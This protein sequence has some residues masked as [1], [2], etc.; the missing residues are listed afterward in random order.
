[1]QSVP[2]VED[3]NPKKYIIMNKIQN[4]VNLIGN[5][6]KDPEIIT[7]ES[8]RKLAKFPLATSDRYKNADGELVENT[9][10]HQVV[11]WGKLVEVCENHVKK[12]KKVAIEGKLV[13]RSYE[14]KEGEK[15]YTCE[16]NCD[17]L[18]LL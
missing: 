2:I 13:H 5:V 6:G 18:L 15:R 16:I 17:E 8:Q 7:F 10:W 1:M 4:R 9:Q 11:V 12:G 14:T 3:N